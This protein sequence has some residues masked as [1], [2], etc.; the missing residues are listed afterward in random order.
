MKAAALILPCLIAMATSAA[1]A[2]QSP[3]PPPA[4]ADWRTPDPQNV[5][6]IDTNKGRIVIEMSPVAAPLAVAR[7]RDLAR[8]G[9]YNGQSFFRVIDGFMDQTGDP[10]NDG[11]GQS[12][13]PNL[14]PEFTFRRDAQTPI[15]VVGRVAGIEAGFLGSLPVNSQTM[16]LGLLTVDHKVNAWGAYCPGV[17]GLARSEPPDSANSQ[18]FLMR[19]ATPNLDQKYTAWGRAI[20]GLDVIRAIKVGE[21]VPQPQDQMATVR[22][23]ADIPPA[24]RPSV[25]VI[26]TGGAWFM[27]MAQRVRAARGADFS[28]CDIDLPV[29]VTPAP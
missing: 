11:T 17:A 18:F 28:I 1:A 7:V 25:H 3:A 4:Q 22:V 15:V 21:P 23:L 9:F 14:P 10:K 24:Q 19:A 13:K 29:Q 12:D 5:L 20:A 8:A 16:D 2:P 26:D 6:V 27:A